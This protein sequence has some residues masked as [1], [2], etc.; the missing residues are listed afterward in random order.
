LVDFV[1]GVVEVGRGA[2][3]AAAFD[4]EDFLGLEAVGDFG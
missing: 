1:F 2:D 4:D 3:A